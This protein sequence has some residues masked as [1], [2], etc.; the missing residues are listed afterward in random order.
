MLQTAE[1]YGM[2]ITSSCFKK[3]KPGCLP[4]QALTLVWWW[5]SSC[6]SFLGA[7]SPL[8]AGS[9]REPVLT[10]HKSS[11]SQH[12]LWDAPRSPISVFTGESHDF[13]SSSVVLC[14]VLN[15]ILFS[16]L[17]PYL[18]TGLVLWLQMDS[19]IHPFKIRAQDSTQCWQRSPLQDWQW[20]ST[21]WVPWR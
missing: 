14:F 13:I 4:I 3:S 19:T 15:S 9:G 8:Q 11:P 12:S 1:F 2:L 5:W 17:L 18:L 16:I 7:A 20:L 6:Y 10:F 21:P